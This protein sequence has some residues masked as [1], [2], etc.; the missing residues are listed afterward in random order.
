MAVVCNKYS[1]VLTRN[2]IKIE[3]KAGPN[4]FPYLM[5]GKFVKLILKNKKNHHLKV[6]VN[7][8]K[9]QREFKNYKYICL[10]QRIIEIPNSLALVFEMHNG[11]LLD[12]IKNIETWR[13]NERSRIFAKIIEIVEYIHNKGFVHRDIKLENI[14]LTKDNEPIFIDLDYMGLATV[15]DFKGT[16]EYMPSKNVFKALRLHRPDLSDKEKN[17]FLDLY[18]LGKTFATLLCIENYKFMQPQNQLIYDIWQKWAKKKHTSLRLHRIEKGD[19]NYHSKWWNVVFGLCYKN[20]E[21][22]YDPQIEFIKLK[23]INKL[24]N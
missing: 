15:T 4:G 18:A 2:Y 17:I 10:P 12:W 14:C 21:A 23:D 11:D 5:D 8:K 13:P 20:E 3:D 1:P 24:L 6:L 19:L 9:I 16:R 22:V 7:I